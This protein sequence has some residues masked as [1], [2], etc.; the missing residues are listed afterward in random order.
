[1]GQQLQACSSRTWVYE[2]RASWVSLAPCV[3]HSPKKRREKHFRVNIS[4]LAL[5]TPACFLLIIL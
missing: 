2:T 3:V 5:Q 4:R 1:M